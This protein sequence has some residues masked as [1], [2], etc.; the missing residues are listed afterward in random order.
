MPIR[1]ITWIIVVAVLYR[2]LNRYI[3]PIFRISSAA[4][5]HLRKMQ[6]QMDE[7]NQKMNDNQGKESA[8]KKVKMDGDYIEYEE[9]K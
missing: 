3:L 9:I 6:Q 4:S 8:P 1:I 2:I 7:M 5:D